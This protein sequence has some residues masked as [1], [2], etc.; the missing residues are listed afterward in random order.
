MNYYSHGLLLTYCRVT[1]INFSFTTDLLNKLCPNVMLSGKLLLTDL[2]LR[3]RLSKL[4]CVTNPPVHALYAH[5]SP[6]NI[7]HKQLL[8]VGPILL[9]FI[10]GY[11]IPAAFVF[12]W[13][14]Y[15]FSLLKVDNRSVIWKYT[16]R[17]NRM[18]RTGKQA[19]PLRILKFDPLA[20]WMTCKY[21]WKEI[22]AKRSTLRS[23]PLPLGYFIMLLRPVL[24][25]FTLS[26][27][28]IAYKQCSLSH[29]AV[30]ALFWQE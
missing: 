3:L 12:I 10:I 25:Q 20:P 27:S 19:F 23:S 26:R 5:S 18:W 13:F 11:L 1:Y 17:I 14:V 29:A 9:I 16:R 21:P 8:W 30:Q 7:F 24:G 22:T 4:C 15:L 6:L 2:F 28:T